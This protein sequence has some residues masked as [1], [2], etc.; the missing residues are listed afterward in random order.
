MT[1]ALDLDLSRRV[2]QHFQSAGGG[3]RLDVVIVA[4]GHRQG[5]IGIVALGRE[6]PDRQ[7]GV[8]RAAVLVAKIL[9]MQASNELQNGTL[10]TMCHRSTDW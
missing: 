1:H 7:T 6:V 10:S 5:R 3:N 4:L 2:A 8:E 9:S